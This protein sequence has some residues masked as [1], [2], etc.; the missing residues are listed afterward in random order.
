MSY[1]I[2]IKILHWLMLPL[3]VGMYLLGDWMVGLDYYSPW[4]QQ[5][6]HL[7]KVIGLVVVVMM[8]L[9]LWTRLRSELPAPV[10]THK[11]RWQRT[12][13]KSLQWLFYLV[14]LGLGVSGYLISSAEGQGIDLIFGL[15]L[16][17][18]MSLGEPQA[19]WAGF[20][21][22]VLAKVFILSLLLHVLAALKHHFMDRDETLKR[23][24]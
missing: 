10:A 16:P 6:P 17:A 11:R 8:L 22:E 18:L 12:A 14:V 2:A 13:A 7:H 19:E 23:M 21:H 24:L 15:T 20:I 9:R 4:Y 1:P 5:A 3:L